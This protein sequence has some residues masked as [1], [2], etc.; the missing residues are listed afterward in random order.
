MKKIIALAVLMAF[1]MPVLAV[2]PAFAAMTAEKGVV[3]VGNKFCPVS[4]DPV[5][6]QNF[7]TYQGKRY[8]LCCP[9]CE[10]PFLKNPAKYIAKSEAQ[11]KAAQ[12]SGKAP[13]STMGN[14]AMDTQT[15]APAEEHKNHNM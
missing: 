15:Q 2:T 6:G 1:V 5:S 3:N 10:K 11:E 9:M 14:M 8:G 7:V 13:V 4:G 12:V